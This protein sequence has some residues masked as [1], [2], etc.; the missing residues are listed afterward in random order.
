MKARGYIILLG[1]T[2]LI[3]LSALLTLIPYS[4][5]SKESY[6]GYKALCSFTP[7]ST[8]I[9]LFLAGVVCKVRK[10]IFISG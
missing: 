7:V 4:N 1:V 2:I 3:T 8:V 5:A 9:C 10:K 6:F